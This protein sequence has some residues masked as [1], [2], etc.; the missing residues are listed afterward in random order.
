MKSK[1]LLPLFFILLAQSLLGQTKFS[2]EEFSSLICEKWKV[3][4]LVMDGMKVPDAELGE[5]SIEFDMKGTYEVLEQGEAYAGT[6]SFQS[7]T[8]ELLTDD[9]DGKERHKIIK[10]TE[11]DL[12]MEVIDPNG[13]FKI[14]L[15]RI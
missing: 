4:E 1:Y 5:N 6:W 9:R 14:T 15:K 2:R 7:D 11:V 3:T 12:I 10:L 8:Q 13:T